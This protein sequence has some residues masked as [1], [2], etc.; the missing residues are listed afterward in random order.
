M[1]QRGKRAVSPAIEVIFREREWAGGWT[2]LPAAEDITIAKKR[3]IWIQFLCDAIFSRFRV[4]LQ[5]VLQMKRWIS[6]L[7]V[8]AFVVSMLTTGA[9]ALSCREVCGELAR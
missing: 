4:F 5:E 9:S 7:A 6:R 3:E 1:R 8:F 2:N